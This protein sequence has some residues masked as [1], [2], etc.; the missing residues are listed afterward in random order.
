MP[1]PLL[2]LLTLICLADALLSFPVTDTHTHLTNVTRFSYQGDWVT[3]SYLPV[4]YS[5]DTRSTKL[6]SSK[7]VFMEA[8][9]LPES[10]VEEAKWV[11]SLADGGAHPNI[12]GLLLCSRL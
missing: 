12:A 2:V 5:A 3:R 11:Q 7:V 10:N 6:P 1:L 8:A 4:N 9:V